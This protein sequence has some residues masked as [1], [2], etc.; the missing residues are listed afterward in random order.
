MPAVAY[1]NGRYGPIAEAAVSIEDRG[2]QFAD[3]L[4]EVVAVMN[5]RFLDWDKHL[6]RLKRGLAALFIEGLPSDAALAAIARRLVSLSRYSDGL[7]Y[8][9]VS[10]GAA[11]R[12][13]GFPADIPA[14]LVMTVRRFNFRQRLPQLET[15]VSAI[16]LP[17]QR[18]ARCDIKTTGLLP[19][20]L[21]KQEARAANAFEALFEKDGIVTEGS[22]TN[23]YMVAADG[24]IVT[25]PL[26]ASILPGIARDTLLGLAQ[27]AQM[28]V[29]ERP[30]TLEEARAAPELFLTS[31]TAPIL[32]IVQLDGAAVG[33]G[34]PGPVTRRLGAL[35]WAE[36]QRQTGWNG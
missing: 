9:Q 29:E 25:H 34:A 12:D 30:F 22:S 26:S 1:V 20:V 16:S 8:I 19:A 3:S 6:W 18:W 27:D 15:G 36:I 21:A 17:D 2:F 35:A 31:T 4:Y 24:R 28:Q 7:L 33:G 11:K 14:T 5:G 23:L 32:P 10:R 13:H